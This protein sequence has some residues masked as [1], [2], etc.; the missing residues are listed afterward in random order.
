MTR[1]CVEVLTEFLNP[2]TV[3]TKNHLVT[4]DID[5]LGQ[6]AER[7]AAMV[8]ISL[9]TL[10]DDLCSTLEPR[11]S[12]PGYRLAAIAKLAQAGIPVGVNLAP[13]IPGLTDEEI[14]SLLE[15]AAESGAQF[16]G[17]TPLRLPYGVKDLFV[18]WLK[19]EFPD[20]AEKVLARIRDIRGGKLND[21]SF[22]SRMR[23][24]GL[25]AE[26]IYGLFKMAR[27]KHGL[28][29]PFPKLSTESFR[30][31]TAQLNLFE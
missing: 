15:A 3:I 5:L 8:M 19:R 25:Y 9:T 20:R 23:G 6:L 21:A 29:R 16:A 13:I 24:E 7:G 30:R 14:P 2:L 27:K 26:Q 17:Y 22:E 18:D 31:P 28:E 11:T 10:R 1:G 4:R 12:R